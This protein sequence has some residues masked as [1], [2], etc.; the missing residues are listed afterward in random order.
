MMD[1]DFA[2]VTQEQLDY[3][4]LYD[5]GGKAPLPKRTPRAWFKPFYYF[6]LALRGR[7]KNGQLIKRTPPES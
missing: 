3:W 1:K 4:L 6:Y 5:M 7:D 2:Y